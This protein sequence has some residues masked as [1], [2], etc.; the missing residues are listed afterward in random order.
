MAQQFLCG[1]EGSQTLTEYEPG[2][3]FS[4]LGAGFVAAEYNPASQA[5]QA[6]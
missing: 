2:E 3:H 1:E 6:S 5:L 4:H